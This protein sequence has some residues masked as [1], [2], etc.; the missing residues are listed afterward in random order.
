M[1][2]RKIN[3]WQILGTLGIS[4]GFISSMAVMFWTWITVL[5]ELGLVYLLASAI[6]FPITLI[7]AIPM[8]W[9]LQ[10]EFPIILSCVWILMWLAPTIGILLAIV[11]REEPSPED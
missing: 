8:V 4:V 7:F 5:S 3:P 9:I 11:K 10:D 2:S 6:F 1:N